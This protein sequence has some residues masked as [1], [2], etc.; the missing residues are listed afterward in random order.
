[1]NY[2]LRRFEPHRRFTG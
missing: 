1:M 2:V